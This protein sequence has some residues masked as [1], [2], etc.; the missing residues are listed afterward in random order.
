MIG[1]RRRLR[2]I[3]LRHGR[4]TVQ[5]MSIEMEERRFDITRVGA[6]YPPI[7]RVDDNFETMA[8]AI[9]KKT[10]AC[11]QARRRRNGGLKLEKSVAAISTPRCARVVARTL[12]AIYPARSSGRAP[13]L[14][15][16]QQ[17]ARLL[18]LDRLAPPKTPAPRKRPPAIKVAPEMKRPA[19]SWKSRETKIGRQ[20]SRP[21][22]FGGGLVQR[23]CAT[24]S[25]HAEPSGSS[26]IQVSAS[27]PSSIR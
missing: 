21:Y 1:L 20:L 25:V 11:V 18:R 6:P 16:A 4:V 19:N 15:P 12:G 17:G 26:V 8:R 7:L 3:T 13:P 5:A 2:R 22:L 23:S 24:A 27:L 14:P 10:P 9:G